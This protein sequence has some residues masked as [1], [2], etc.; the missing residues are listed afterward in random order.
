VIPFSQKAGLIRWVEGSVSLFSLY[1]S[2]QRKELAFSQYTET[3]AAQ[4]AGGENS[5]FFFSCLIN[6][7][8]FLFW[9]QSSKM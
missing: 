1:K 3:I 9:T 8:S 6:S 4:G 5:S 2:W 7:P